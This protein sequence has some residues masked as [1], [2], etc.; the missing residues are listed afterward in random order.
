MSPCNP[1]IG[2]NFYHLVKWGHFLFMLYVMVPGMC[3]LP[4]LHNIKNPTMSSI[5]FTCSVDNAGDVLIGFIF[6]ASSSYVLS[7][8]VYG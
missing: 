4:P 8:A 5:R 7:G 2:V 1:E 3:C 6:W